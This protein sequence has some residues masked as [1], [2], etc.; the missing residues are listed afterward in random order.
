ML[1]FGNSIPLDSDRCPT[2]AGS[3]IFRLGRGPLGVS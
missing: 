2:L 1:P 3:L